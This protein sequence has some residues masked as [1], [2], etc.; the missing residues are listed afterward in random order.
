MLSSLVAFG[1]AAAWYAAKGVSFHAG[2]SAVVRTS[3]GVIGWHTAYAVIGVALGALVRS[4]A[5]AIV[6]AVG[7]IFLAETGVAGL[8]VGLGR[9]L[10]ATAARALGDDP[11]SGLLPQV[12]AAAVLAGWAAAICVGATIATKRRDVI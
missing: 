6:V 3:I 12:G 4:Q 2:S 5:A 9:W 10:P 8:A 1:T 7:W 11:G